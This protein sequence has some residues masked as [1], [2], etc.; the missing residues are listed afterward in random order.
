MSTISHWRVWC[1]TDGRWEQLWLDSSSPAPTTCPTDTAH[2]IDGV[3]T[4]RLQESVQDGG[5]RSDD[6]ALVVKQ[7]PGTP[8]TDPRFYPH[9]FKIPAAGVHWFDL[10]IPKDGTSRM[11]YLIT[12]IRGAV[13]GDL[14]EVLF[15]SD[16]TVPAYGPADTV[17]QTFGGISPTMATDAGGWST[18]RRE[19][20]D[21]G[22]AKRVP[23]GVKVS[24]RYTAADA[25]GRDVVVDACC[26]E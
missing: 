15:R 6:G 8:D 3:K 16:G 13:L 7:D 10:G 18:P 4:S 2:A 1:D 21:Q 26:H 5:R 9:R 11:Q 22:S 25:A 17:L 12:Q 19:P 24:I 23:A 14:L 20:Q